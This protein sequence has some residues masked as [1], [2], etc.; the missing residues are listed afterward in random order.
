MIEDDDLTG[1]ADWTRPGVF[2]CAPD[3]YRIP[4]PLPLDG[5]RAVNVYALMDGEHVVLV[6]GGWAIE[7]SL[8]RLVTSLRELGLDLTDIDGFLVT[9]VHRDHYTQAVTIRREPAPPSRSAWG[10]ARA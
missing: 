8:G 5:L 2:R 10:S 1:A 3:V 4:L 7:E 9:H 6:D